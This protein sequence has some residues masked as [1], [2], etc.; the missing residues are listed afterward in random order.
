MSVL[1]GNYGVTY[2]VTLVV[3]VENNVVAR[4]VVDDEDIK[5][6]IDM[7]EP[8]VVG[9]GTYPFD[10]LA[11]SVQKQI[12]ETVEGESWPAWQHGF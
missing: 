2:T 9:D 4:V 7:I 12:M 5:G 6:P 10:K 11:T 8:D 3:E 1:N